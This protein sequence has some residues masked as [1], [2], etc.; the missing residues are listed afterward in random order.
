MDAVS[1]TLRHRKVDQLIDKMAATLPFH[2]AICLYAIAAIALN[3]AYGEFPLSTFL[4]YIETLGPMYLVTLPLFSAV[5]AMAL[6][7][8][9][10]QSRRR[11]VF[12]ALSPPSVEHFISGLSLMASFVLMMGAFTSFK[13]LMPTIWN[14]FPY[15]QVQAD[16]DRLLH[17][18]FDP[19]P[20]LVS[21]KIP[22]VL[23][24]AMVWNYSMGWS[25]VGLVPIYFIAT[26]R[27]GAHVRLRYF[28][29][30]F[31]VWLVAGN[32]VAFLF[33]S[34]GPAFYDRIVGDVSRFAPV[35]AF[36]AESGTAFGT[37][38]SFQT[39]LWNN[40]Q[41]G[42]SSVGTG[43]SAFPSL[44]VAIAM[45]N[46]LFLRE[47]NKTAGWF[48]FIY[49]AIICISSVCL[50]WHYAIDGY[51][52]IAIVAILYLAIKRLFRRFETVASARIDQ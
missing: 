3:I 38:T 46:A 13:T 2:V 44:H 37:P 41:S 30:I 28:F 5:A 45:M 48:G 16:L 12:E 52:S 43:I 4:S 25:F 26:S 23:R 36:A 24:D 32:I 8:S 35:L 18:G 19:G 7:I 6:R 50:G 17:F 9:E 47:L 40:F 34:A 42:T 14:G 21:L 22:Q 33:L 11:T 1:S 27:F 51:A 10:G 20:A 29:S 31:S 49:V 15:D 39:F